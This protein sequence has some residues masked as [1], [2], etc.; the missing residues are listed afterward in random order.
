MKIIYLLGA[1]RSGTTLMATVL[2]SNPQIQTVGE[3]HQFIEH[4]NNNK[5]CSCGLSLEECEVWKPIVK[6][7]NKGNLNFYKIQQELTTKESHKNIPRLLLKNKGDTAYLNVHQKIFSLLVENTNKTWLLDSSKYIARYILLRK[8]K[9][10]KVKGIYVVRDVRGVINSFSKQVQTSKSPIGTI[11]YYI[12]INFFGEVVCRF[13]KDI[14]KIKYEDFVSEPQKFSN[15]I[16]R[17]V[18]DKSEVDYTLPELF[19]IPHIIGGNRMKSN[20][21]I[22]IRKDE[23]WKQNIS[24]LN[25]IVYYI[26]TLP[27]MLINKYKI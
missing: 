13:D 17:H 18:F 4:M 7:M 19:E 11:I 27:F 16:Y 14:L 8:S 20:K 9:E 2:N 24:R 5:P 3:M 15:K 25:Q 6:E 10:L 22:A 12:L 26:L 1:G 21:S 23:K